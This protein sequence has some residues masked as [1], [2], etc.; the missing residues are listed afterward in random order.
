MGT[1]II[2]IIR[3]F[4]K[5]FFIVLSF[6]F[7]IIATS[8]NLPE[9]PNPPKLV[10][11]YT[12]TLSSDE[13]NSLETKLVSYFDSTSTQIVIV[14][15]DDLLGYDRADYAFKLGEK[16]GVGQKDKNNGI[17]ILIKPNGKQGERKAFIAVGRGLEPV[18]T[19]ALSKR[20]TDNEMIPNF[21]E[22]KFYNGLDQATTILMQLASGE[23]PAGY[24]KNEKP[25]TKAFTFF[26]PIFI[27][28]IVLI[29][30]K[31]GGSNTMGGGKS[32][33]FWT[34]L[35][36]LSALN[37]SGSGSW[38]GFSSGGGSGSGGGFGG[39]GGGSFGGGGAGGS[40]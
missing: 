28:I 6:L 4:S 21:R 38:G 2:H 19:D 13:L 23:F 36:L 11:D 9:K 16:W 22:N 35:F 14:M 24:N 32:T 7:P 20:I 8:Q 25:K 40:W 30:I 10:N 3:N 34:S 26:I 39:F 5:Q 18:I 15:T 37:N 29:M 31:K 33:S 27:I 17:V 12:N 1:N